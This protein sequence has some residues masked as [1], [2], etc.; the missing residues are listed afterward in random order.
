MVGPQTGDF[1]SVAA[2]LP[3]HSFDRIVLDMLDPW[4]RLEQAYRVIAPGGVLIAYITTTTQMSRLVEA[5]REAGHWTDPAIQETLERT[6]KAQGLA[7]R[8]DHAMI[9]HTRLPCGLP[10]DGGGV[11]GPAQTRPRHQGYDH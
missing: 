1:D 6:W 3:E 4:N 7:V 11:R 2:G 10:R 9:G 8:P 5:L